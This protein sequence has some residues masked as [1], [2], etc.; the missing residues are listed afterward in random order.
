MSRSSTVADFRSDTVTRPTPEMRRAMAECPVGDDVFGDDPT[1]NELERFAAALF[2]K[3]A[4]L[5][6]PSGT[7]ANLIAILV[8]CR[9]GEEAIVEERSHTFN[10]EQAGAARFGGVQLR[11]LRGDARGAL[12]P[13]EV[14]RAIR[15]RES[16]HHQ[17]RT[18][19]VC[20]ENTH[21]FAGGRVVPLE[22]VRAIAEAARARGARLHLDGARIMNAVVA[23][24]VPAREWA[25]PFDTVACCLSKGLCAPAG[26]L[27]LGDGATI[28]E[29]RRA[30]KPLGG[31]MR[32]AGVLAACGL[33]A[34]RD[35]VA[36]LAEDHENAR[37]LGRGL[38]AVPGLR[39]DAES[40]ETNMV[41]VRH[42]GGDAAEARFVAAL[43]ERGVLAV[44]LPGLGVRFVTHRDVGAAEVGRAIE[45]AREAVAAVGARP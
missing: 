37:A 20:V 7:M 5:F 29:A 6:C 15:P 34:L 23:T 30:R 21:N 14:A 38:A 35:M 31:G 32:Q 33:I 8:H 1:V 22:R 43:R 17:P 19:L 4:A 25:A 12:D 28:A 18:A 16:L 41:F 3:E 27:L 42:E 2:G 26:T 40:I 13:G 44:P 36:R 24:R 39:V 11:P 9:P 10:S 45:A